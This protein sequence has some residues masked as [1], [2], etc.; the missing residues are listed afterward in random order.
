[1]YRTASTTVLLMSVILGACGPSRLPARS[2][3]VPDCSD[4]QQATVLVQRGDEA[5]AT[6]A[7]TAIES[8]QQAVKL[9]PKDHRILWK[10]ALAYYDKGDVSRMIESLNRAVV[11]A[12]EFANYW[13]ELGHARYLQ[14]RNG[15][16]RMYEA[17]IEPLHRCIESDPNYAEC[18]YLLGEAFTYLDRVQDALHQYS[19]AIV[20]NPKK[21]Q[22]YVALADLYLALGRDTEGTQVAHEGIRVIAPS[23]KNF[24]SLYNLSVLLAEAAIAKHDKHAMLEATEMSSQYGANLHPEVDFMLGSTYATMIPVER[25]KAILYLERFSS[26]V[27]DKIPPKKLV[28][29]CETARSIPRRLAAQ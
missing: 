14:G 7:H 10:L 1:M 20:L 28:N 5:I 21:P 26:N 3:A 2:A 8:Y 15:N 12:P 19:K 22:Y 6:N 18:Y 27:C 9:E 25:D 24:S 11:M 29:Q 13:L 23:P 4:R 17:A 16:I